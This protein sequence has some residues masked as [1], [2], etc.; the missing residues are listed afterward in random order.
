M[1]TLTPVLVAALF[2][3]S[4][5]PAVAQREFPAAATIRGENIWLRVEPAEDTKVVTYLQR[6]DNV[7]VTGDATAADGD[8]FYPVRVTETGET[9]WVRDLAIDPRSLAPVA[10]LPEV[11][12][13]EPPAEP[14]AN[15]PD[16]GNNR[17]RRENRNAADGLSFEGNGVDVTEEFQLEPGRYRVTG[18]IQPDEA[19]NFVVNLIGPGD[20]EELLFNEVPDAGT[21]WEGE[22]TV[23]ITEAGD[24]AVQVDTAPSGPW[25][26]QFEPM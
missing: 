21:V 22:T 26:V 7:R 6:G 14:E 18:S 11:V 8:A 15:E 9:G 1:T 16:Q 13:E 3:V 17:Q 20:F 23:R 19:S 24:Y 4:T 5:L 25:T 2:V 10:T 12:V